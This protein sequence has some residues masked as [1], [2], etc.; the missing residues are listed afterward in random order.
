MYVA[1]PSQ[2]FSPQTQ[3]HPSTY[4]HLYT[5]SLGQPR[6]S[7]LCKASNRCRFDANLPLP[8]STAR[9]LVSGNELNSLHE[10]ALRTAARFFLATIDVHWLGRTVN[11]RDSSAAGRVTLHLAIVPSDLAHEFV[12][13]LLNIDPRLCR[14]L[15]KFAAEGPGKRFTI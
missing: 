6:I 4:T 2:L 11:A 3:K 12:E 13:R 8:Y 5:H 14:R 9:L 7:Q 10:H 1:P 15:G